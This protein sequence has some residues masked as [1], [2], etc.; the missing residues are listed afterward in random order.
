MRSGA[1]TTKT[2]VALV[3]FLLPFSCVEKHENT[4]AV[5]VIE[6]AI[7]MEIPVDWTQRKLPYMDCDAI[8]EVCYGKGQDLKIGIAGILIDG[9]FLEMRKKPHQSVEGIQK[10]EI[11]AAIAKH[12]GSKPIYSDVNRRENSLTLD[13]IGPFA[14][15]YPAFYY[16]SKLI[17]KG[18]EWVRLSFRGIDSPAFRKRVDD[19]TNSLTVK[20]VPVSKRRTPCR[21]IEI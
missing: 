5:E 17:I 8:G 13:F 21:E 7:N 1:V 16:R 14:S 12:A 6:S 20:I 2:L 18:D 10:Q 4:V 19:I 15:G 3:A 9:L 11:K